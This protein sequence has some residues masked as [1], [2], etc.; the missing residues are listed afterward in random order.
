MAGSEMTPMMKQ[1]HSMRKGLPEDCLLLFRLGDFYEMFYEDAMEAGRILNLAVTK[2]QNYPMAGI[3]YHAAEGYIRRLIKAGKRVAIGEQVSEPIPGKLVERELT[4]II[5]AGTVT[6]VN[7]LDTKQNNYLAAVF[8]DG[9][10]F[11]LAFL[12]HTTGE[13]R[14][15][16][17]AN[18]TSLEDEVERISPAEVLVS[19]EQTTVFGHLKRNAPADAY[20]FLLDQAQHLLKEHFN[21]HSLDGF[22]CSGLTAAICAAGGV[23]HYVK[24]T[25]RRKVDHLRKLQTYQPDKYVIIDTASRMNLDL[26]SHRAGPEFTLLR[27]LDKTATPM[28]ARLLRE[29]ILHPIR[30]IEELVARQEVLQAFLGETFLLEKTRQALGSIRDVERTVGRL[31]QQSGNARDLQV[32]ATSLSVLPE[33]NAHLDTLLSQQPEDLPLVKLQ[34][35]RPRLR[36]F[37]ETVD[38]L[39]RA[40]VDEPPANLKDGGVFRDGYL[41]DL[42][43]LRQASTKGKEWIAALQ[44]RE[45]ERTGIKSLKVKYNAV[46]GYFIEITKSNVHAAPSDYTRKQTTANGE[47]YITPELKQME[48]KILGSDERAKRLEQEQFLK[49]RDTVLQDLD[50]L[51]DTALAVAELD[52]L[53]GLAEIARLYSYTRPLLNQSG[54]LLIKDGRHPVLD[55]NLAEEKFVPNDTLLE[56]QRNRLL[57]LTGPN[58]AGKSTYIRQVA[59][60]TLMAQMGSFLPASQAE[61]GL[62]DRI[63]TRVGASDDLARGQSTFMVEMSETAAILNNATERSLVILDEIGRGTATFDGLAIA[64]SVAEHLH[65]QLKSRTLFATHY[66]ELTALSSRREGVQ[67]YSIAVREW[68]DRIIFLRK[69]I[70]GAADKSYGIQVARLAGLPAGIISRAREILTHL[71]AGGSPNDN[72]ASQEPP[73]TNFAG[74]TENNPSSAHP[75]VTSAEPSPLPAA[76]KVRRPAAAVASASASQTALSDP[77]STQLELALF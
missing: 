7:M 18:Q 59:L 19:E 4:Q 64:W 24:S 41:P 40:I 60:L 74:M 23:L 27:A 11:G 6:D 66:H 48:D 16:E 50:A 63:F 28:G 29:W 37:P 17:F 34:A 44:E 12:D 69:I 52:V 13:F 72:P 61:I 45:I 36:E 25:L 47:R 68:N 58:M 10:H 53:C 51:Q 5:S 42:D 56:P 9:K 49:L 71:E 14:V 15:A 76:A 33:L 38:L 2:R 65:D 46:F 55:Q 39:Q 21:V 1:Y 67:N 43:E 70:A 32:L 31:G 57:I 54:N 73:K 22:G 30:D 8:K 75:A 20:S 62:V 3:P 35:L 26:V 77:S